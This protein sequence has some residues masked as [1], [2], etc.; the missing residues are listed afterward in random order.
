MLKARNMMCGLTLL[1]L[2]LCRAAE[3]EILPDLSA[4]QE[5][6]LTKMNHSKLRDLIMD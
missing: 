1:T 6:D 4:K 3:A 2:G 5:E